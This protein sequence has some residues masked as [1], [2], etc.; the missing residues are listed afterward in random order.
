[1]GGSRQLARHLAA[2]LRKAPEAVEVQKERALISEL[3]DNA[4][5]VGVVIKGALKATKAQIDARPRHW[6]RNPRS[7]SPIQQ[8]A[9][10]LGGIRAG[11]F[12]GAGGASKEQVVV[13]VP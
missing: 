9:P 13:S 7:R 5:L 3:S 4:T 11:S 10:T 6:G 8:R 12:Q 1:G 2:E